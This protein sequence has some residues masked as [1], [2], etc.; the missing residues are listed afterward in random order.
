MRKIEKR[1]R[2]KHDRGVVDFM[3]ITSLIEA[4]CKENTGA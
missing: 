1:E 4:V 2:K 3:M